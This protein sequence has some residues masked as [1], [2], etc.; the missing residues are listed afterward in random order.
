MNL[1]WM[2]LLASRELLQRMDICQ[3]VDTHLKTINA[4]KVRKKYQWTCVIQTGVVGVVVIVV[5]VV[6][7]QMQLPTYNTILLQ[8]Q[9]QMFFFHSRI[10][11]HLDLV[12]F[13][14][15]TKQWMLWNWVLLT[16][17][18]MFF[19]FPVFD[20]QRSGCPWN[21]VTSQ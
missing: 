18:L 17:N 10:R 21:L 11:I 20:D 9:L 4:R 16:K 13:I 6:D 19:W 15:N 8:M 5:V 14:M 7:L 2:I 3:H 12:E 1:S